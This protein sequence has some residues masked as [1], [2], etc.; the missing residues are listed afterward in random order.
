MTNTNDIVHGKYHNEEKYLQVIMF[1]N[2][3]P[4]TTSE[5]ARHLGVSFVTATKM[6]RTLETKAFVVEMPIAMK[7]EHHLRTNSRYWCTATHKA[8]IEAGIA[9]ELKGR[10]ERES[11]LFTLGP[12]KVQLADVFQQLIE[13]SS[14]FYGLHSRLSG[15][16]A[17]LLRRNVVFQ[18]NTSGLQEDMVDL[19]EYLRTVA[20]FLEDIIKDDR[21]WKFGIDIPPMSAKERNTLFK[22]LDKY[23]THYQ[24]YLTR[25]AKL[26][27]LSE[28]SELTT[29]NDQP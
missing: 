17:T 9:K 26:K 1:V 14:K 5:V 20:Q 4:R 2:T 10:I 3:E 18:T 13:S 8:K 24:E 25:L 28:L 29:E 15:I 12:Y 16:L 7:T 11:S 6:L 21:V 19:I 23:Y 27:E 22:Q